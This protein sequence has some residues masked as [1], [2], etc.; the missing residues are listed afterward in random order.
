[1]PFQYQCILLV[2][3]TSGI[4][5]AL[6]DRFIQ[7][8]SKVIAV[9]R[10]QDRL[11]AFVQ[12][13]GKDR[14]GAMQFDITDRQHMDQFVKDVTTTYPDLDCVHLNSG[15]QRMMDLS[16]PEEI[17]LEVFHAQIN[18][19]FSCVV[20]MAIKFLPFLKSKATETGLI[21]TSSNLGTVPAAPLPAYCASKAALDSFILALREKMRDT[22]VKVIELSLP[23]VQ[24]ELHD[25]MGAEKGRQMGMPLDQFL[26]E[27]Y[28]G[29]AAGQDHVIVGSIGPAEEFRGLVETRRRVFDNLA[30]A[31]R[32]LH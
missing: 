11:D 3:A 20:D 4:G 10:R 8:G 26:D 9:G 22:S 31:F 28:E 16:R 14:A 21:F 25:Y 13:H 27:A 6:A 2:G 23:A 1:M 5:A 30:N 12:K 7:E 17:D 18:T 24:T 29:L 19:N 15:F 32:N